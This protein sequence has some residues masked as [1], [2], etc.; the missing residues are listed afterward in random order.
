MRLES[1]RALKSE[2]TA[3]ALWRDL[4]APAKKSAHVGFVLEAWEKVV[5]PPVYAL[6]IAG[7]G[8]KFELAVRV[9]RMAPG[10]ETVLERI[11]QRARGEVEVR[12]VGRVFKQ[13][14]WHRR[15]NRPLEI[16]GSIGHVKITAGTLAAFVTSGD[17]EEDWLLSNNHVLAD[18]DRAKV[19]DRV[20]QP[21]PL[22][23]GRAPRD[24][25]GRLARS[26]KLKRRGNRVDAATA[27]IA[28]GVEY[29]FNHLRTFGPLAGARGEAVDLGEIVH[30]LGRTTGL[31]K[32]RV[33]AIELDG[34]RV[35]YDIG[36]LEFDGQI[37]I[38][39]IAARPFSL[40]GDSGSLVF[41]GRRRAVGLLFAGNDVDA[42]YAS[43]I[44]AVLDALAARLVY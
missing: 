37:E 28:E 44:A 41:D 7:K 13:A 3:E 5:P 1:V 26:V 40:G 14:P 32:G 31:T 11:H 21:G 22:D 15:K 35:G 42:T 17:G 38:E 16:G 9:Q 4:V 39:P 6:G 36:E 24:V 34:L 10:L 30:K 33:S 25:V 8:K 19:G 23:G 20:V 43:P 2:L 18:E 27:T 12:M 29:Y